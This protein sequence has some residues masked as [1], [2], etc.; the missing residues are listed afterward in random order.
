MRLL[1]ICLLLIS[2]M[3]SALAI[4][5][6]DRRLLY[7]DEIKRNQRSEFAAELDALE[8]ADQQLSTGQRQYLGYLRGWQATYAGQY[9][10]AA[11]R[12]EVLLHEAEDPIIRFRSRATLLNA[13][14]LSR[15]YVEG[16]DQLNQLLLELDGITDPGARA[17]A[18]G[19][20]AQL[21]NQ[22]AQYSESLRYSTELLSESKLP[23]ARCGAA[24]LEFEARFK[25]GE[26]E[27]VSPPL[28]RWADECALQGEGI[29]AGLLRT[30]VARL[31]LKN[32]RYAD[33]IRGLEAHRSEYAATSYPFLMS[34]VASI[35]ASAHLALG[36][37]D[38]AA[39]YAQESIDRIGAGAH[40][41][42]LTE[43]WRVQYQVALQQ[44]DLQRAV[45]A[46]ETYR[47]VD[48]AYLDDVGQRALAFEMARHEAR[49]KSLL[50][51]SLNRQNEVLQL[52]QQ[53]AEKNVQTARL[54]ILL[55]LT[56]LVFAIFWALRTRRMQRHFQQLAQCDSLT[57]IASRPHFMEQASALLDQLGRNGQP[58]ALVVIDLDY[59]KSVNDRFGHAAGDDVLQ[60]AAFACGELLGPRQLFGRLGGEEFAI[61]VPGTISDAVALAERC[62]L[63]L[64]EIS[65]GPEDQPSHLSGSFG[66]A[67]SASSGHD[68]RRMMI[69]ADTALY[70]AKRKGRNRVV[71]HAA[72]LDASGAIRAIA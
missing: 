46:L 12:F 59:F 3:S 56:I 64:L 27:D 61:L 69:D 31:Q 42:A 18:L 41:E 45:A 40:T 2:M 47:E 30:Y 37:L 34:D 23:W 58:A 29:F 21:L 57:A 33:A 4:D 48:R 15:R 51:Q 55:L 43:A 24:Q 19:V 13:L 39:E 14:T 11:A 60:R 9:E 54:S 6:I 52:Q 7:A 63:A 5:D 10:E 8:A 38:R 32:Q 72:A 16:F 22:V 66:V 71:C 62:R 28:E 26:L 1:G 25:S 17:Q 36:Q 49:A 65:F 50:I 53:V 35:L 67:T 68:L 70:E 44:G 20:A